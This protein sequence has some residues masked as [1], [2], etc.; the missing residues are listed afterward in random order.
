MRYLID[1]IQNV[2]DDL[3]ADIE[4]TDQELIGSALVITFT[5][6]I[7][8]HT[9]S[10]FLDSSMVADRPFTDE[11]MRSNYVDYLMTNN[12]VT[13]IGNI[14]SISEVFHGDVPAE[15]LPSL[16]EDDVTSE[17]T[18]TMPSLHRDD[19]PI[20]TSALTPE[21]STEMI[22]NVL[23]PRPTLL[24]P[25]LS[26]QPT[27]NSFDYF[28]FVGNTLSPV[29]G[30]NTPAPSSTNTLQT[31]PPVGGGGRDDTPFPTS[32]VRTQIKYLEGHHTA[33]LVT[34]TNIISLVYL[35]D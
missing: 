14:T 15:L 27:I 8:Y 28:D 6:T 12:G 7:S 16:N 10:A 26:P 30:E 22:N 34:C 25:G 21:P 17:P 5:A 9:K 1:A 29:A 31:F 18:D 23:T 19:T 35:T 4:I 32:N 13:Y 24:T 3:S 20:P 2:V 33:Q 11:A